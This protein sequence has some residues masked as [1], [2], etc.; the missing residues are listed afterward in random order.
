M[1]YAAEPTVRVGLWAAAGNVEIAD[2]PTNSSWLNRA[3]AQ[4]TA[5]R[6]FALDGTDHATHQAQAKLI[7]R[8]VIWRNTHACD[9]RLRRVVDRANVAWALEIP[10]ASRRQRDDSPSPSAPGPVR[11]WFYVGP[12]EAV[13]P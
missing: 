8:Y 3:E 1:Q 11:S 7:R 9:E 2:T 6:Y 10:A 5:L 4:F 13:V 12:D